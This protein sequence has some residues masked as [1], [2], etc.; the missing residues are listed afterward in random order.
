MCTGTGVNVSTKILIFNMCNS[1]PDGNLNDANTAKINTGCSQHL[2][3]FQQ[4]FLLFYYEGSSQ[5][6][7][8]CLRKLQEL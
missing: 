8:Y 4:K 1:D 6:K 5:D 3:T 7:A 2:S